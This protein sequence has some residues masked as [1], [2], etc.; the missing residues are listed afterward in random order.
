[1][2]MQNI[3]QVSSVEGGLLE[4]AWHH[5]KLLYFKA[6]SPQDLKVIDLIWSFSLN[7]KH[8]LCPKY[9]PLY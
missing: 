6:K 7:L 9:Y 1:M 2:Y 8:I 4:H 5:L 3:L